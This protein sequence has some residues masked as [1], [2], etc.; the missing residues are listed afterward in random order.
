VIGPIKSTPYATIHRRRS[1]AKYLESVP[2][3]AD[4]QETA[5]QIYD[6][7]KDW[8]FEVALDRLEEAT[9]NGRKIVLVYQ[10]GKVGSASYAQNLSHS[11]DIAVFH[12]HRMGKTQ[13]EQMI[14]YNLGRRRVPRAIKDREWQAIAQFIKSRQAEIHVVSA[15]RDPIARNISAFFQNL[16][17]EDVKNVEALI[18]RFLRCYAHDVPLRWFDEQFRDVLGID[19]FRFPFNREQGWDC[20]RDQQFNCLLLTAEI[21]DAVKLQAIK[22]FLE[23]DLR[24][25]ERR[26]EGSRKAY[27]ELYQRF[28][29]QITLPETYLARLLE[30]KVVKHFYTARQ[31]GQF[32]SHWIGSLLN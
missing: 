1:L 30:S 28:K 22:S 19:I 25:I 29:G 13:N 32:R 15:M 6:E 4:S 16:E 5:Y 31:I 14:A 7:L 27:A 23:I 11:E 9:S 8:V 21:N 20:F 18:D 2:E 24:A 26:N 10:M 17:L 12:V 3:I